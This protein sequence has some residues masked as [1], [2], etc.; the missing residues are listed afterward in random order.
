MKKAQIIFI[1]LFLLFSNYSIGQNCRIGTDEPPGCLNECR[2]WSALDE[3]FSVDSPTVGTNCTPAGLTRWFKFKASATWASIAMNHFRCDPTS[4]IYLQVFDSG[5]NPI[6]NCQKYS[7]ADP[8]G[9]ISPNSIVVDEEYIVKVESNEPIG[10]D[11]EIVLQGIYSFDVVRGGISIEGDFLP[12][13]GKINLLNYQNFDSIN[14]EFFDP[15]SVIV[16][17][18]GTTSMT[19][20]KPRFHNGNVS[21]NVTNDC[22]LGSRSTFTLPADESFCTSNS[23]FFPGCDFNCLSF[24][25]MEESF[26]SSTSVCGNTSFSKWLKVKASG[27]SIIIKSDRNVCD[28]SSEFN[29]QVFDNQQNPLGVCT[30]FRN[31]NFDAQELIVP[32]LVSGNDYSI[33][34]E[35]NTQL[36][37]DFRLL[38]EGIEVD[39]LDELTTISVFS[40]NGVQLDSA[41]VKRVQDADS[42]LWEI[43][44]TSIS[45]LSGQGTQWI[46]FDNPNNVQAI[47]CVTPESDCKI[48]K[49]YCEFFPALTGS[50]SPTPC[51]TAPSVP[52][53]CSE[54]GFSQQSA[55]IICN[56]AGIYSG[57]NGSYPPTGSFSCGI[58][59]NSA[60]VSVI[61]DANGVIDATVITDNCITGEGLQLILWDDSETEI[62]CFSVGG[63]LSAT[64]GA[65]GLTPGALYTFQIDGFDGDACDFSIIVSGANTSSLPDPPSPIKMTP[66]TTLCP[67]A[68]V[69]FEIDPINN[70]NRFEWTLP[71]NIRVTSGGGP[72]DL[73][74]C[75][76]VETA[77]GGAVRVTPSNFCFNGIPGILPVVSLPIPPVVWAPTFVCQSEMPFDTT[78]K[79]RTYTFDNFGGHEIVVVTALGCDSIITFSIIPALQLPTILD[80]TITA[81]T[82]FQLEDSCYFEGNFTVVL[83]NTIQKNGCDSIVNLFIKYDSTIIV[84]SDF[85]IDEV[86]ICPGETGTFTYTGNASAN[87]NYDWDFGNATIVS[88]SGA[89]PYVV[90]FTDVGDIAVS[91]SVFENGVTSPIT[92]NVISVF[93]ALLP[94]SLT[95][96]STVDEVIYT[97]VNDP[98]VSN[99]I[100]NISTG[101]TGVQNGNSYVIPNLNPNETVVLEVVAESSFGCASSTEI[102]TCV[103]QDCPSVDVIVEP[104]PAICLTANTL[105]IQL[106]GQAGNNIGIFEWSGV[107]V[108]SNGEFNPNTVGVG[109]HPITL[110]YTVGA[111]V[112][113]ATTTVQVNQTPFADFSLDTPICEGEM[114]MII[115]SGSASNNANF[116]WDFGSGNTLGGSGSG[117]YQIEY[118]DASTKIITLSIEDNGCV[119]NVA[120]QSIVVDEPLI[121]TVI[122]CSS[123]VNS[124]SFSWDE[125]AGANN[126][127]VNVLTGQTGVQNGTTYQIDNLSPGEFVEIEVT[128]EGNTVC[129]PIIMTGDCVAQN[130]PPVTVDLEPINN[131]CLTSTTQPIQ[132]DATTIGG[133][134]T[135]TFTFSGSG[136][137]NTG[138]FDPQMANLGTNVLSV[139]YAEGTCSYAAIINVE[140]N[141]TPTATFDV[142]N[143]ICLT[144]NAFVA[145]SGNATNNAT[146]N[147]DFDV[148]IIVN[149]SNAGPYEIVFNSIGV[150]TISLSVE[151]NG[152]TSTIET[153]QVQIDQELSPPVISC[154][155][156]FGE[157]SFQWTAD[158]NVQDYQVQVLNGPNGVLNGTVYTVSGLA[159]GEDVSIEVI[160]ISA[161]SCP[162]TAATVISCTATD[163]LPI[164]LTIDP[165]Q[166]VLCAGDSTVIQLVAT[167]N[168]NLQ[169]G[170]YIWSGGNVS[171][172]GIFNTAGLGAGN[173]TIQV[174]YTEMGCAYQASQIV[175]IESSPEINAT[176]NSPIWFLGGTGSIDL[177]IMNGTSPYD[178]TRSSAGATINQLDS[179]EPGEYKIAA[180]DQNGCSVEETFT[181]SEGTYTLNP[182]QIICAGDNQPLNVLPGTGATFSWSPSF[183]LSCDDCPNPV[184]NP[185]KTT[186]YRVTV[187]LPDGRSAS[188]NV[189][190]IVLPSI[191]CN[192]LPQD[193]DNDYSKLLSAYD[194]ENISK[195]ELEN[196]EK[197]IANFYLEKEV[198]VVPNPTEGLVNIVTPSKVESIKVFDFSGKLLKSEKEKQINLSNF[199]KGV[200]FFKIKIANQM[201]IKKVILL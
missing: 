55:C 59:H 29:V 164:G 129:G 75:G 42:Y 191:I 101:Q 79:G 157:I 54:A 197:E 192:N 99:Y 163:C 115:F 113:S 175:T 96:N 95:C 22:G 199:S 125:V 133:M 146:Y 123:T 61:S 144:E 4:E 109:S 84:T 131:V 68:E 171:A 7:N 19:Y 167:S 152:C 83:E 63:S 5:L 102:Q 166:D 149:G 16:S 88:G 106:T 45:I 196:L 195:M 85:T 15:L 156:T 151:E 139:E 67:G 119:S 11:F 132:L 116:N 150:K 38:F 18:Q 86:E 188:Q 73:F 32:N 158:P 26:T 90:R 103:A 14:W 126:Y 141:Q 180:I 43:S 48:G 13:E 37:C 155:P 173:Y 3:P 81:G 36:G 27:E 49:Q 198:K 183:R 47:I 1:V 179:L 135:G 118:A 177:N 162:S 64:V 122:T 154:A 58:P 114:T 52:A 187:T 23:E 94:L 82:C 121:P 92:T 40:T 41:N 178:T 50:N 77:G 134:G 182:I 39:E 24:W 30:S 127:F 143:A 98:N 9:R 76:I 35:T 174:E 62:D 8:S 185:N 17:G 2:F 97:W 161:N 100:F 69:C 194:V 186:V 31:D 65:S 128:A 148:G 104:V 153:K 142:S 53:G 117:P 72:T 184:A 108:N 159:P 51:C 145:Y 78:I 168:S 112:Y 190:V 89:G 60:Y 34:I 105:P 201:I 80:T 193:D 70:S 136:V 21:V 130:C 169:N 176:V 124:V 111:C 20:S 189:V 56:L 170:T 137:S 6:S 120:T 200:Y 87:A 46:S 91:L 172:D 165:V 25:T 33:L 74:V 10:C 160:G 138:I 110:N 181:I 93:P 71:A 66:D 28:A 57:N 44:D 107:G 140:V 147:W 12:I